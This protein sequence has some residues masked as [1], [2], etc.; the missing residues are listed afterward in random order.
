MQAVSTIEN[1]VS[2]DS[3]GRDRTLSHTDKA[4]A[5]EALVSVRDAADAV[6]VAIKDAAEGVGERAQRQHRNP[7]EHE[8]GPDIDTDIAGNDAQRDQLG[9]DAHLAGVADIENRAVG[10]TGGQVET[11]HPTRAGRGIENMV[12]LQLNVSDFGIWAV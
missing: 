1:E 8:V 3:M 5:V 4:E 11:T 6:T 10:A 7:V 9:E 12:L 2:N